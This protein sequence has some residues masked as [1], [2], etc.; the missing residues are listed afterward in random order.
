MLTKRNICPGTRREY[1][2]RDLALKNN[3]KQHYIKLKGHAELSSGVGF[4]STDSRLWEHIRGSLRLQ[5]EVAHRQQQ[6][7]LDTKVFKNT[8]CAQSLN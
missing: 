6:S 8:K 5:N 1:K 7:I 4:E 3:D 2:A